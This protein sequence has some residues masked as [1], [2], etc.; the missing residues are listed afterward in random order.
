MTT[1]KLN[2]SLP[3]L[4]DNFFNFEGDYLP[5][6]TYHS[7]PAVNVTETPDAYTL[8][9]AAP[10]LQKDDFLVKIENNRL[11]ISSE[12]EQPASST[13]GKVT[14]REFGYGKFLR[15]FTLPQAANTDQIDA[16]YQNGI[17]VLHILKKEEAKEKGPKLIAVV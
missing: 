15:S 7:L 6:K 9:L 3:F 12:K 11:T 16:Q 10:G 2:N 17:L 14:R 5:S 1:F 8:E 4:F 13:E